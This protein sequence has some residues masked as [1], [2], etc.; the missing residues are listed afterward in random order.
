[1]KESSARDFVADAFAHCKFIGYVEA[2]TPLFRK[3]G[4]EEREMDEGCVSLESSKDVE[5]FVKK[6]GKLRFWEREPKVKMH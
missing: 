2:A 3:A 6:L 1:M 4:I 5:G